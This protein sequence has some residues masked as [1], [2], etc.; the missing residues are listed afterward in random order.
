LLD[1]KV[2]D[3]D[4]GFYCKVKSKEEHNS[5]FS[6][7][8]TIAELPGPGWLAAEIEA[9]PSDVAVGCH[10]LRELMDDDPQGPSTN[11]YRTPVQRMGT[12]VFWKLFH[13]LTL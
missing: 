13:E 10:Q 11:L 6:L 9:T 3:G 7:N 4:T 5:S 2:P 1:E 8:P 12:A